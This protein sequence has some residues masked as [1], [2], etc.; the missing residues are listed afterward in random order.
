MHKLPS[1]AVPLEIFVKQVPALNTC[2]FTTHQIK[3]TN[4]GI[5]RSYR[6]F[7]WTMRLTSRCEFWS[8]KMSVSKRILSIVSMYLALFRWWT[9]FGL[10]SLYD[11]ANV[12]Y[13]IFWWQIKVSKVLFNTFLSL[14][15]SGFGLSIWI[16]RQSVLFLVYWNKQGNYRYRNVFALKSAR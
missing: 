12:L 2:P 11:G 14:Q 15:F 9:E 5:P 8:G 16:F 10:A 3:G 13:A 6:C 7:V 1:V 4:R